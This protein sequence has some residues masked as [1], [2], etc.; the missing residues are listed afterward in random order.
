LRGSAHLAAWPDGKWNSDAE[1]MA[2]KRS[3]AVS[4]PDADCSG[5]EEARS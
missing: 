3:G 5:G 4:T 1:K 2:K